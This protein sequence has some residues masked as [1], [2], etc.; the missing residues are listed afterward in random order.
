M[1]GLYKY[2]IFWTKKA[3]FSDLRFRLLF[4]AQNIAFVVLSWSVIV[5]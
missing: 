5:I 4:E 2:N 1:G 3:V